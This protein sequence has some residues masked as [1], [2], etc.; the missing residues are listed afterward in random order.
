MVNWWYSDRPTILGDT[1]DGVRKTYIQAWTY[2][3]RGNMYLFEWEVTLCVK[4]GW[5]LCVY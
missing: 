4:G 1:G 3:L 5:L 2:K